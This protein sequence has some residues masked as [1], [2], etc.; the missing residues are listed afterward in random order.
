M[1]KLF[2]HKILRM[3]KFS[4]R[5][6]QGKDTKKRIILSDGEDNPLFNMIILFLI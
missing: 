3:M 5:D 2:L 6:L 1:H 4:A